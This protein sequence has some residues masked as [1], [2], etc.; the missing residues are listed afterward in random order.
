MTDYSSTSAHPMTPW[1]PDDYAPHIRYS[2][3]NK[4]A[5]SG[6][7][8]LVAAARGYMTLETEAVPNF[9]ERNSLG[10][11]NNKRHAQ[12]LN[13][14][15]RGETMVLLWY[16]ADQVAESHSEGRTPVFTT[17]QLRPSAPNTNAAGKLIKY[18]NLVG[19]ESVIDS[20]PATPT[21]WYNSAPKVLITEGVMKGDSA[22]SALL[23]ANGITDEELA[24]TR[25]T[26]RT[27]AIAKLHEL[28]LRVPPVNRVLTLSLVGVGN[29]KNNDV[30]ISL[31]LA[32]REL[33]LAFDG[34]IDSNWNVW[35]QADKLWAFAVSK[36][37][38]VKLVDLKL[39]LDDEL[40][41]VVASDGGKVA[42]VGLDDYLA[43]HGTWP[44]ILGR[45]RTELP[46]APLRSR[47]SAEIGAWK[48]SVDGTSVQEFAS[49][50]ALDGSPSGAADWKVQVNI[51]G[52]VI[53]VETHRAPSMQEVKTA[54]FGS[55]LEEEDIPMRST[56]KIELSW[57]N[58]DMT[59]ETAIVTGPSTL[60]MYAPAEWDKRKADIP[61][62]LLLHPEWPP[63]K[64]M[65]WLSA[66]KDNNDVPVEQKVS[67]TTMGWVPV[68]DSS[69]CSFIAGRTII[70]P[71]EEDQ[72]KTVAGVDDRVLPGSSLFSLPD[73][74][75]VMTE[76][77]KK[78]VRID[79]K[80][81]REYYI[82]LAPWSNVNVAAV[83]LA[84]GLRP[85]VPVDCTTCIWVQGPPGQ[86]KSWTVAQILSFHQKQATWTN[87]KLPGSMKDTA[88]G[89]E[90]AISQAN[91]WV[92]DDLAP[93]PD[94]RMN[95]MEQA[96]IGDII[97]SV[98]NK[99]S[100]RRSGVDLKAREVFVPHAL[101]V[102][103]AENE[104]TIN[105]VRDRTVI[106]N[107][108][109]NS[110][111]SDGV[112]KTMEVFRDH[113]R[114]P[115]RLT[116]ASAQAFQHFAVMNGW[117]TMLEAITGV[118]KPDGDESETTEEDFSMK[119][120]Y[121]AIAQRVISEVK[122]GG[123]SD[124]RH[125][126]MAV[127]LMLGLA[128]LAVL[129]GLVQDAE[130]LA[131]MDTEREDCLP[132]RVAHV[133]ATSFQSQ[134]EATPGRAVIEAIRNLIAA[135]G[136]HILNGSDPGLPPLANGDYIGNRALGWQVDGQDKPR[137]LGVAIGAL[138]AASRGGEMDCIM[139]NPTN[140]F[141]AAQKRYPTTLPPG[142]SAATSFGSLW[143][144]GLIHDRF[145]LKGR[146]GTRHGI[147]FNL[148]GRSARVVPIH[149]DKIMGDLEESH[150][151]GE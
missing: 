38:V 106:L 39:S 107:L 78:Q 6:V 81:I 102:V 36:K 122:V 21:E 1:G 71:T 37:A 116:A 123:K 127:D 101:L 45:M 48:V 141:D 72:A 35:N 135:G 93:S 105:S 139:L 104:H 128:P 79:L 89:V 94:K 40:R 66:I 64:G 73:T 150:D 43:Q 137:P 126:E 121:T 10:N 143:N 120:Q 31:K 114:A 118:E 129:A 20:N 140:A 46:D 92:M 41:Q 14:T 91:I 47:N 62:N 149:I 57:L 18:E 134:G 51:G 147:V 112:R 133:L 83:V 88:T 29:W 11:R 42:K 74:P 131:L 84:A 4:L 109:K 100:K 52:R 95:D 117:T 148:G 111:R 50:P 103:T 54:R 75:T 2:G 82:D 12:L 146:D 15:K 30:W 55:G 44:E 77:W 119:A 69:V 151:D 68:E 5:N 99:S 130:M 80:A 124:A 16:R 67:W 113:N 125:V 23:R 17:M 49:I 145:L 144:E 115:G 108:D 7:A 85:A 26:S 142:T 24:I 132:A 63:E 98:Y 8:P 56:C 53:A 61:N 59:V 34:D 19:S 138:S 25:E 65:K 96:K 28:M 27:S 3:A 87:K 13:V 58:D 9:A 76:A 33:M 90:Q 70:S 97:R 22:L 32:D 60:L 110:L 136:A 86:G